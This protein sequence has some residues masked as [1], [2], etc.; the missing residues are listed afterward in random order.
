[1]FNKLFFVTAKVRDFFEARTHAPRRAASL[2]VSISLAGSRR[3][4][5]GRLPAITEL[6]QM[7]HG[8]TRDLSENGLGL[9]L[10]AIRLGGYYLTD[11][12]LKIR[13]ALQLADE[14]LEM[15]V[16]PV[17]YER[18]DN[19]AGYLVGVRINQMDAPVR[20]FYSKLLQELSRKKSSAQPLLLTTTLTPK[21][22]PS[23]TM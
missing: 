8:N 19:D 2:P 6:R 23:I 4:P 11:N 12:D 20:D 9:V 18:L 1:M 14:T 21:T 5:S 22:T 15:E 13:L 7:M 10:P 3:V 17:R 16:T